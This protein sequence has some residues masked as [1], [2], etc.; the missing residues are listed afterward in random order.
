MFQISSCGF[1]IIRILFRP[2]CAPYSLNSGYT[3]S[4]S[5]G[6]SLTRRERERNKER[7]YSLFQESPREGEERRKTGR[8]VAASSAL[9]LTLFA[10]YHGLLRGASTIA[11]IFIPAIIMLVYVLWVLYSARRDRLKALRRASAMQLLNVVS[12]QPM[13][14]NVTNPADIKNESKD[15]T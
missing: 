8:F 10:L 1:I 3:K 7:G 6:A 2:C 11:R 15:V 12:T 5:L 14:D 13:E 4:R 9:T